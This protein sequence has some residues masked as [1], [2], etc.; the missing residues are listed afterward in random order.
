MYFKNAAIEDFDK[1]F[2]FIE[3]L[4]T[5]NIYDRTETKKAYQ[6]ILGDKNSFAFF[7]MEE[8]NYKGFCHCT[9]FNT[10]WLSGLTC[11]L[12]GIITDESVRG[13]GYGIALMDEVKRRAKELGCRGIILDSGLPRK[14][15]HKFYEKYGFDKGCYGFDLIF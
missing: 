2:S 5:Y 3:K 8:G 15:A 7:V 10:F 11:Y 9:C 12:S 13:E 1:A 6:N 4:W 14:E